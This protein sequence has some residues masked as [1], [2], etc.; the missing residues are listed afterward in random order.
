VNETSIAGNVPFR[1]I[2][3]ESI[4]SNLQDYYRTHV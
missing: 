3:I 1:A 2:Y 4:V